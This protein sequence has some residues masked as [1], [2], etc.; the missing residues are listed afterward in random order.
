MV[1]YTTGHDIPA[2]NKSINDTLRTLETRYNDNL[3]TVNP[4]KTVCQVFTLSTKHSRISVFYY[5]Q[6]LSQVDNFRDLSVFFDGKLMRRRHPV[7]YT[8]SDCFLV[9]RG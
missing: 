7:S 2:S 1:I 8:P 4:E 3:M 9:A 6:D 5:N